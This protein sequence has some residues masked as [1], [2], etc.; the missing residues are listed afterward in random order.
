MHMIDDQVMVNEDTKGFFHLDRTQKKV[1]KD[2][3]LYSSPLLKIQHTS[4]SLV[5]IR[6]LAKSLMNLFKFCF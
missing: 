3:T 1:R 5:S 4:H 2:L 6:S